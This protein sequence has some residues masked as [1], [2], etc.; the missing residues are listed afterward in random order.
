MACCLLVNKCWR[1]G[2]LAF[3]RL[4]RSTCTLLASTRSVACPFCLAA[5]CRAL[6]VHSSLSFRTF[7][8]PCNAGD[9]ETA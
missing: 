2:A 1:Q 7:K 3:C 8:M 6:R 5:F 9:L 4:A